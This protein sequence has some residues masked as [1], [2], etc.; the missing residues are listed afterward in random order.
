VR[1]P[2][3]TAP[4]VATTPRPATPT[5]SPMLVK[6]IGN[7]KNP[8]FSLADGACV[9]LALPVDVTAPCEIART[10]QGAYNFFAS[11][12]MN[13]VVTVVAWRYDSVTKT[14]YKGYVNVTIKGTTVQVPDIKLAR[15]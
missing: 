2:T 13:Q 9:A 4:P 11:G 15:V 10:T 5:P 14:T 1:T 12:R 6:F 8:D 7:V 3:P